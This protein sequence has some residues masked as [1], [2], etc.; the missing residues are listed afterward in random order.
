MFHVLTQTSFSHQRSCQKLLHIGPICV[1][2]ACCMWA[3][4][5]KRK[6]ESEI[7]HIAICS[8]SGPSHQL[9]IALLSFFFTTLRHPQMLLGDFLAQYLLIT[10]L[11]A[12]SG[13]H[14]EI[15]YDCECF[16][17]ILLHR[18]KNSIAKIRN[19]IQT[20]VSFYS[21][22]PRRPGK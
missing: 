15:R 1:H 14:T 21:P 9:E 2:I 4:E 7:K 6:K 11:H 17:A 10:L 3:R 13:R 8:H 16:A 22:S 12:C 20:Q 5:K 19:G 18:S